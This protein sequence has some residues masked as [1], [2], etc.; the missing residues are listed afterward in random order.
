MHRGGFF[1]LATLIPHVR[2]FDAR[3]HFG[4]PSIQ[5]NS[6]NMPAP[7]IPDFEHSKIS[8]LIGAFLTIRT[9]SG[10]IGVGNKSQGSPVYE[11]SASTSDGGCLRWVVM[12]WLLERIQ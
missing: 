11:R 4:S 3:T 1:G 5:R 2:E 10:G 8:K 12:G 9:G 6:P 7:I